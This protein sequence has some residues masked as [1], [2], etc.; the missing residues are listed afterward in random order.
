MTRTRGNLGEMLKMRTRWGRDKNGTT[1]EASP[2]PTRGGLSWTL[3]TPGHSRPPDSR[4]APAASAC[5]PRRS[6]WAGGP[7]PSAWLQRPLLEP[8]L[9]PRPQN[10]KYTSAAGPRAASHTEGH[11]G[12]G[13]HS[14]TPK[15]TVFPQAPSKRAFFL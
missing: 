12:V 5:S 14:A 15:T 2:G 1:A 13:G 7:N 9:R 11:L 8:P 3:R 10:L 6:G 4:M